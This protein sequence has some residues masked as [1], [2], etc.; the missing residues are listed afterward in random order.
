MRLSVF[1]LPLVLLSGCGF[2]DGLIADKLIADQEKIR[3]FEAVYLERGTIPGAPDAPVKIRVRF[4]APSNFTSEVIEP[5]DYAGD[6]FA[7]VGS[8]MWFYSRFGNYGVHVKNLLWDPARWRAAIR[9]SVTLNRAAFD[10]TAEDES[11][12]VAN[13]A[14]G[15]YRLSPRQEGELLLPGRV[16]LDRD[17]T[18]PLKVELGSLYRSQIEE[19]AFNRPHDPVRFEPPTNAL[20]FEYDMNAPS[21]T[22]EEVDH[23]ADFPILEPR[24]A[25]D[26]ARTKIMRTGNEGLP[27]ISLVYEKGPFLTSVTETMD[28]G[29]VDPGLRGVLVDLGEVKG[30]LSFAAGSTVIVF[31]K[32]GVAVSILTTLPSQEAV[33]FARTLETREEAPR[34]Q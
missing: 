21:L 30:R 29:F 15:V 1:F 26:F 34:R 24:E 10:Y 32:K 28:R 2:V 7:Y 18:I 31:V 13:R 33:R 27:V 17:F 16:W 14:A 9:A 25:G 23:F 6:A 5:V 8:E 19:I 4:E 20:W 12:T 22:E 3:S 11:E